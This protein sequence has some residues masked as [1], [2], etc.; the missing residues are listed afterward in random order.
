MVYEGAV[1]TKEVKEKLAQ[2]V[3]FLRCQIMIL[4]RRMEELQGT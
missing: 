1:Q 4:S 2:M 3:I